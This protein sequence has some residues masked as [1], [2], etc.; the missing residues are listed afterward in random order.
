MSASAEPLVVLVE[1]DV[2]LADLVRNYLQRNGL[3]VSVENRGDRVLARVQREQ[4]DLIVLDLNLPGKDGFA[5]CREL[6]ASF[7]IPILMLTAR[8]SD[9]DHV[10]G[11]ELG[12][13]DY[14]IKPVE[15]RVLVA[16]I[17]ALLRRSRTATT[18]ENKT[19]RFGALSINV[20]A[21]AVTLD[22]QQISLS[23]NEF[24]LL[25]YLASRPGEIQ[26]REKLYEQLYKREYNGL[27]RTLDVR[28]SH[29]RK[30]LGDTGDPERIRT[31]WGHG[32]LFV[33]DAW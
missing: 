6:R 1:D 22:E 14:V 13:D 10:V 33:P 4:P 20:T 9:I 28:I 5:V 25:L 29:L 23:S 3:R 18:V 15:P 11:L 12:A 19:V 2:R 16:R 30:K 24:D 32:Y 17:T 26:S 7:G 21:R 31:V 8:D 27:D